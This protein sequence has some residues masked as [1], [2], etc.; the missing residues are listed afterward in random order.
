MGKPGSWFLPAQRVKKHL[1]KSDVLREM[2]VKCHSCTG[3]FL[4]ILLA[5][6]NYLVCPYVEYWLEMG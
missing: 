4:H 2:Q 5:Q 1:W 3:V 6:T